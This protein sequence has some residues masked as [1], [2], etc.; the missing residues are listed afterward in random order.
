MLLQ[1]VNLEGFDKSTIAIKELELFRM[2][3]QIHF[4]AFAIF[5]VAFAEELAIL[6]LDI[7]AMELDTEDTKELVIKYPALKELHIAFK[8]A[9]VTNKPVFEACSMIAAV[10]TLVE[11][12]EAEQHKQE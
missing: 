5:E 6:E 7:M 1:L 10:Q 11:H 12:M 3:L 9:V 4:Q 8:L 2:N